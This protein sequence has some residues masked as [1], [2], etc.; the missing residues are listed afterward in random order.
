M[1]HVIGFFG[2]DSQTGTTMT[3]WSFAERLSAKGRRV[4][5]IFGSGGDDQAV[6]PMENGRSIDD[7]KAFLRSG[8]VER[9]ELFQCLEKKK[10]LWMLHGTKNSLTAEYFMEDTFQILLADVELDFD[11]VVIDGGSD[12]RLGLT[13]SALN[14][15]SDRFFVLTQQ[16]KSLHRYMRRKQY[17][18]DPLGFRGQVI[19]NRYRKDPALF[20][21]KDLC[22][23]LGTEDV[24]VIPLVENGW[25]A[26]L[27]QK[28]LLGAPRFAKAIEDLTAYY[29]D[30][31]KKVKRWKRP[32][33]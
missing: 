17:F 12:I 10:E 29:V 31:E 23:I 9:E 30:E 16:A 11:D 5:L 24:Y 33:I 4:L 21:K 26:E 15:C 3:A 18:F 22:R 2:G 13:V 28:N 25:Q 27:E 6:I 32:F 19:V 20:L 7:L 8:R 1:E 14:L